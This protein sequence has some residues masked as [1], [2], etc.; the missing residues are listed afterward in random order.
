MNKPPQILYL[1]V[2]FSDRN[3]LIDKELSQNNETITKFVKMVINGPLALW[4]NSRIACD[5]A[6]KVMN[7]L[8]NYGRQD[9]NSNLPYPRA[10]KN[11]LYGSC[12]TLRNNPATKANP[13]AIF[14]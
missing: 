10:I 8:S 11:F 12:L 14:K 2:L 3:Y 6:I 9:R 13:N 1:M 4:L 5:E 7:C